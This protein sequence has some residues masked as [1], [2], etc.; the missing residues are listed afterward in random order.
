MKI[1]TC[2]SQQLYW[3][4]EVSV[5]VAEVSNQFSTEVSVCVA[6]VRQ[7][8]LCGQS[9]LCLAIFVSGAS[10][11]VLVVKNLS[12]SAGNINTQVQSLGREEPLEKGMAT[13]P[14]ILAWRIPWT[15]EPGGLH[16]VAKS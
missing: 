15:E 5:C 1:V 13:H 4:A 14:S 6:E 11:V 9:Q 7:S 3:I 16:E 2:G 10:Q 8:Q 12:A